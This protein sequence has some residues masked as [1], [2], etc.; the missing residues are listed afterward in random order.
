MK[1]I[2]V[3]SCLIVSSTALLSALAVSRNNRRVKVKMHIKDL[4]EHNLVLIAP[5]NPEF[6]QRVRA[7]LPDQTSDFVDLIKTTS[8]F[9]ENN[10]D[11]TIVAYTVQWAFTGTDGMND[12]Y[13]K[14][15]LS[16]QALIENQTLSEEAKLQG[17]QIKPGSAGLLSYRCKWKRPHANPT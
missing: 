11:K 2:I 4:P 7:E 9:L 12:Y 3:L 8:V 6:D 1:K 13:R 14:V 10:T 17:G 15:L 5:Q 16:P